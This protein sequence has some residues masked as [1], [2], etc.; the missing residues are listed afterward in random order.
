MRYSGRAEL[1]NKLQ[2]LLVK[3]FEMRHEMFEY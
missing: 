2:I 3:A 1:W